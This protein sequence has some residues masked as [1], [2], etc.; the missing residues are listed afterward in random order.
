MRLRLFFL[1][2][3]CCLAY[4]HV[5]A[6]E[7]M[8]YTLTGT[9]EGDV[10]RLYVTTDYRTIDTIFIRN[11]KFHYKGKTTQY[12]NY[13]SAMDG[14][15]NQKFF[16]RQ[17]ERISLSYKKG[18]YMAMIHGSA[19]NGRYAAMYVPIARLQQRHDEVL[20]ESRR[21]I[22]ACKDPEKKEE[23]LLSYRERLHAIQYQQA[24]VAKAYI[25]N[26]PADELSTV[27]LWE[28][29]LQDW[30]T[31]IDLYDTLDDSARQNPLHADV[32]KVVSDKRVAR[33]GTTVT[34]TPF[35][36]ADGHE[37][38]FTDLRGK[39][40]LVD[41]WAS[42]CGPCISEL[43]YFKKIWEQLNGPD[44]VMVLVSL[45]H[46][47]QSW[48]NCY[49]KNCL[50][51]WVQVVDLDKSIRL[52]FGVTGVPASFLI[53]PS[54]KIIGRG[55]QMSTIV[56]EVV[57]AVQQG[58]QQS[59]ASGAVTIRGAWSPEVHLTKAIFRY[60]PSL[61]DMDEKVVWATVDTL[62]RQY[63]TV[64]PVDHPVSLRG[65]FYTSLSERAFT[66]DVYAVPGT[67][68]F[69]HHD[70]RDITFS[71][72]LARLY[73][74]KRGK[75]EVLRELVATGDT[76][77]QWVALN[78]ITDR[79]TGKDLPVDLF[80]E[81]MGKISSPVSDRS[82]FKVLRRYVSELSSSKVGCRMFDFTL[83]DS[84]GHAVSLSAYRGKVVYVDFWASWCHFCRE[85][86]PQLKVLHEQYKDKGFEILGV[87]LDTNLDRWKK[88]MQQDKPTWRNVIE[89]DGMSSEIAT[90]LGIRTLPRTLLLNAEGEIIAKDPSEQQL[91]KILKQILL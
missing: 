4:A 47:E 53:S 16:V 23:V 21:E 1:W 72:D 59:S 10:D 5:E 50:P 26:H 44:F 40:V 60:R 38:R 76:A 69:H 75:T 65:V 19:L 27:L 12:V 31:L 51:D 48:R 52:A 42:W 9:V 63:T 15:L 86:I 54:G 33:L 88:A 85:A 83:P 70:T 6:Q 39:F 77:R 66:K 90:K 11:G 87:S 29:F 67:N 22:V 79:L 13:L 8:G 43:S 34:D 55:Y 89:K 68:R 30:E 28:F 32:A 7:L 3:L 14:R 56:E 49:E 58:R 78:I 41:F 35:K 82:D 2:T 37:L 20:D 84:V 81:V 61:T 46:N 45:D 73:A 80:I 18:D 25:Q 24:D 74:Q 57:K 17:G 64:I 91:K 36:D 71:N 62:R